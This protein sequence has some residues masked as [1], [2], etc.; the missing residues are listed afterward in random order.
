MGAD[1][2]SRAILL[3]GEFAKIAERLRRLTVQ[4]RGRRVGWGSGVIW[5]STGTIITNAHVVRAP[6]TTVTLADGRAFEATVTRQD[7][8]R[9]LAVLTLRASGLPVAVIG[10]SDAV[11]VGELVLAVGN[12]LGLVGALTAGII[13]TIGPADGNDDQRWIR[14]DIRLAPG[15]SGGLLANAQGHVVGINSMVAGGLAL[16]VPS[17]AVE[18][19]LAERGKPPM[20]G[21]TLQPVALAHEGKRILGLLV[22]DVAAKGA[23]EA[24]GIMLGDVLLGIGGQPLGGALDLRRALQQA[25]EE[26]RLALDLLRGGQPIACG[27]TVQ[28]SRAGTPAA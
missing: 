22:V 14:A 25:G 2:K 23:A 13:H 15:N 20:L 27:V 4:V 18:A 12:P 19:F 1:M 8:E 17:N 3:E 9:D 11:R 26:G 10:D 5:R 6:S 7:P 28:A 16:A 24:A 21:V